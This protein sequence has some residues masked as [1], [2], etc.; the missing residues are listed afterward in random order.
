MRDGEGGI[1]A[2]L[3]TDIFG[4]AADGDGPSHDAAMKSAEHKQ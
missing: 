2:L 3:H 4:V 1:G